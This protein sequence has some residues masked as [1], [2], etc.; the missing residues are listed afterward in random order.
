MIYKN[1]IRKTKIGDKML[2]HKKRARESH[3]NT[4][5]HS[6]TRTVVKGKEEH[7]IMIKGP[8]L[9]TD[10]TLYVYLHLKTLLQNV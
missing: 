7:Y 2:I 6:R 3:T 5:V 10:T 4:K 1:S 9:Q 8:I